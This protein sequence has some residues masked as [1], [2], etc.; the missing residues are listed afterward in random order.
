MKTLRKLPLALLLSVLLAFTLM[1]S[2]EDDPASPPPYELVLLHTNDH[3]GRMLSYP[4]T[5]GSG[6]SAVTYIVGGLAERATFIDSVRKANANVLLVDSGDLNTGTALSNMFQGEV[7]ILAYNLMGYDAVTFGNHEFNEGLARL[8]KQIALATFP[9]VSSNVTRSDGSFLGGNQYLIK[10]YDGFKVGIIGITTLRVTIISN[11]DASLDFLPEIEAAQEAVDKLKNDYGVDIIIAVTHLGD[12]KETSDFITSYDLAEGVTGID[13]IVDG[14]SHSYYPELEKEGDTWI[15]S[16]HQWGRYVG[17]GK[18]FISRSSKKIEKFEWAPVEIRNIGRNP[19]IVAMMHNYI[20][21]ADAS[22]KE[23]VGTS[24]D[25]YDWANIPTYG[26]TTR[27]TETA[28]GNM[29]TDSFVWYFTTFTNQEIDFAFTNGGGI[30]ANLPSG[31]ITREDV[32]T[33]L[34]FEN[35]LYAMSM[36]GDKLLELFDFIKNIEQSSGAFPQ[37]SKEVRYTID[38]ADK[39]ISNLTVGGAPIDPEKTYRFI[40]HDF[41]L[42]GGDGYVVIGNN[43][44]DIYDSSLLLSTIVIDYIKAQG[45]ISP[46]LDGRMVVVN[47]KTI[48]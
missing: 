48:P 3:H 31:E 46:A 6:P 44:F 19:E 14:H 2:C 34:P 45:T 5:I 10:E 32:L 12:V 20:R 7:D 16:A 39:S 29:I 23:V 35:Y 4:I 22:L 36:T 1:V 8:N 33:V 40:A 17:E 21:Q 28:I 11:P 18:I 15:V 42:S 13:I 47:G 41:I 24:T 26:V 27:H 43:A 38:V 9:F 25:A 37:F 30:R